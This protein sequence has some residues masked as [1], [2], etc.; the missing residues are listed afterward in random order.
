[1]FQQPQTV[2]SYWTQE[3]PHAQSYPNDLNTAT[4]TQYDFANI[5]TD[6][7]QPEE[8][9]QLDQP[10]K[11]D[12]VT[13]THT[14]VARSPPT[15]LDLGSGTIHREFKTEEYWNQSLSTIINDDSN[16]SCSSRFNFNSSP[17]NTQLSLNNNLLQNQAT[18]T[19]FM[20]TTKLDAYEKNFQ[21]SYFSPTVAEFPEII[22]E[23]K[24][25]FGDENNFEYQNVKQ[26]FENCS[27]DNNKY[28]EKYGDISQY[29]DYSM[30][31]VY[32][33][34]K[35]NTGDASLFGEL[36]FRINSC[37]STSSNNAQYN[38]DS[39]KNIVTQP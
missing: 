15:L 24:I 9:F 37:L 19:N 27:F 18:M 33:N 28:P 16:N 10:I 14:E 12:F 1:M 25:F 31:G 21:N 20:E 29:I 30:I 13:Q 6:L 2:D 3:P 35:T 11:P 5:T 8:I 17:D 4:T 36:D 7:F 22:D 32:D 26:N 38:V 39:F 34:N 23:N